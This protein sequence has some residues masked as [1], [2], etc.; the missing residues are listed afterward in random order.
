MDEH[1]HLVDDQGVYKQ[2]EAERKAVPLDLADD[3]QGEQ[4]AE[5]PE[6]G[7]DPD[8]LAAQRRGG[9]RPG[10]NK[11][12]CVHEIIED[13]TGAYNTKIRK[14]AI[15]WRIRE[16]A[17]ASQITL[18]LTR[19]PGTGTRQAGSVGKKTKGRYTTL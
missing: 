17:A 3:Q 5:D 16:P 19:I 8:P 4:G 18:F 11:V 14:R 1:S 13:Y 6:H 12:S 7:Q 9:E 10:S 15:G 2:V